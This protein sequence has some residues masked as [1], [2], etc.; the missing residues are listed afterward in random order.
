MCPCLRL[1]KL[2]WTPPSKLMLGKLN[3]LQETKQNKFKKKTPNVKVQKAKLGVFYNFLFSFC[4]FILSC[5]RLLL[6][7]FFR[8]TTGRECFRAC[9]R[10]LWSW[11]WPR[12]STPHKCCKEGPSVVFCYNIMKYMM[13]ILILLLRLS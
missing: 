1:S 2:K 5:H 11:P 13:L 6:L 3:W 7:F 4:T 8:H 9:W 12:R 10:S